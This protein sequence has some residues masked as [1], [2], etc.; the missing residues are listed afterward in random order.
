M[1][2]CMTGHNN[3]VQVSNF[4]LS[5]ITENGTGHYLMEGMTPDDSPPKT[6]LDSGHGPAHSRLTVSMRAATNDAKVVR[7]YSPL[8]SLGVFNKQC[9]TTAIS[10]ARLLAS[11]PLMPYQLSSSG[12]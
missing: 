8:C 7:C 4:I 9:L 11:N 12:A 1:K 2:P 6:L 3:L 10:L 5:S